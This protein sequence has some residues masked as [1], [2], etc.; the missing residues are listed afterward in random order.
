M[1][2]MYI[3]GLEISELNEK[4]ETTYSLKIKQDT[5]FLFEYKNE[6]SMWDELIDKYEELFQ[7]KSSFGFM[8]KKCLLTCF[9]SDFDAEYDLSTLEELRREYCGS[10]IIENEYE[11][12]SKIIN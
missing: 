5:P 9:W 6:D 8:E 4:L 11:S 12:M 1:E 7:I 2:E 10:I 3:Y